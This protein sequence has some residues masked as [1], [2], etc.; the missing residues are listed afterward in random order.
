MTK[1]TVSKDELDRLYFR[2][3]DLVEAVTDRLYRHTLERLRSINPTLEEIAEHCSIF[4]RLL[5]SDG[6]DVGHMHE[7]VEVIR[8]AAAAVG[9]GDMKRIT[10]CA[11]HL[12]D[13]TT[14]FKKVVGRTRRI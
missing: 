9:T 7:A 6:D 8:E 1:G 13:A 2:L 14:R 5:E 3:L 11:Y 10:D 4:I 12:E